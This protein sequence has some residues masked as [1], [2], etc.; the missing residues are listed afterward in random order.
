MWQSFMH[1]LSRLCILALL[2]GFTLKLVSL[3]VKVLLKAKPIKNILMMRAENSNVAA[4]GTDE[5]WC[6]LSSQTTLGFKRIPLKSIQEKN[7]H[8]SH[9]WI[10]LKSKIK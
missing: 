7:V 6:L 3:E 4:D 10:K 2:K 8:F 9:L 1:L 5:R